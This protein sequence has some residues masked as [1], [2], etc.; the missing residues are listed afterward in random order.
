MTH[1][2]IECDWAANFSF[3]WLSAGSGKGDNGVS[4][5]CPG[6]KNR[7]VEDLIFLGFPPVLSLPLR[8]PLLNMHGA[9]HCFSYVVFVRNRSRS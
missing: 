4:D 1:V 5:L 9:I 7:R 3:T 2:K 8:K 6:K